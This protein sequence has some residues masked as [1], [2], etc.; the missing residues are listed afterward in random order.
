MIFKLFSKRKVGFS[1][2]ELLVIISIIGLLASIIMVSFNYAKK[3]AR[4]IRVITDLTTTCKTLEAYY[5]ETGHYPYVGCSFSGQPYDQHLGQYRDSHSDNDEIF[6]VLQPFLS[7]GIISFVPNDPDAKDP[8]TDW[9]YF[10][11]NYYDSVN[12]ANTPETTECNDQ[13]FQL[14]G[15]LEVSDAPFEWEPAWGVWQGQ[16]WW[17]AC[18]GLPK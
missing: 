3:K 8:S 14:L 7:P 9:S 15:Y 12:P 16:G 2:I 18:K 11:D 17:R 10:Y 4:D 1:L 6:N 13:S 5:I